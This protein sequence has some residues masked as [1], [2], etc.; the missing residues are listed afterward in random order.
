MNIAQIF[1]DA[2]VTA[3]HRGGEL[4]IENLN[5]ALA[6]HPSLGTVTLQQLADMEVP[7][8]AEGK[9]V[10]TRTKV[11]RQAYDE[12]VLLCIGAYDE[13]GVSAVDIRAEVGGSPDQFRKAV[14][15]LVAAG[16]IYST[17]Q[18]RG[19]RYMVAG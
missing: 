19:T 15:R 17:G 8:Q 7:D 1:T 16:E 4:N 14:H 11:E 6:E 12:A 5:K 2:F 10:S 13:N 18:A 3:F 9:Q